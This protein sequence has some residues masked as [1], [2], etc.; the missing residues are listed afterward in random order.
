MSWVERGAEGY[1][2][3]GED[4]SCDADADAYNEAEASRNLSKSFLNGGK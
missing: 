2:L 4:P 1:G 3:I